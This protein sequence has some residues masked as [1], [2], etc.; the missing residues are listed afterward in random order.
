M[1]V[2]PT[3][4]WTNWRFSTH[5]GISA[6]V[7]VCELYTCRL[8]HSAGLSQAFDRLSSTEGYRCA[9][10][11]HKWAKVAQLL[12]AELCQ[13]QRLSVCWELALLLLLFF[14]C[15]CCCWRQRTVNCELRQFTGLCRYYIAIV[16]WQSCL[17]G[18]F[19]WQARLCV[20][21]CSICAHLLLS[22][23]FSSLH[24]L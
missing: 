19:L 17:H 9:V 1:A 23:T 16:K 24:C 8:L 6:L 2:F 22:T 15:C 14:I 13:A 20:C 3:S 21:I 10:A 11:V 7:F 18:I 5:T 12:E 4:M